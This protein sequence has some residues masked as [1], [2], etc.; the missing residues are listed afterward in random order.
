LSGVSPVFLVTYGV[1]A[2]HCLPET[3]NDVCASRQQRLAGSIRLAV[4]FF[5]SC[6]LV[7]HDF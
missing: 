7:A 5:V 1:P 6:C 3:A 2:M 4:F